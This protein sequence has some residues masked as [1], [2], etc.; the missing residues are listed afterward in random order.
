MKIKIIGIASI[1]IACL[2]LYLSR[3][4]ILTI[5]VLTVTPYLFFKLKPKINKL[6]ASIKKKFQDFKLRLKNTNKNEVKKKL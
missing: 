2:L 4:L 3:Y 6:I 1:L 5:G